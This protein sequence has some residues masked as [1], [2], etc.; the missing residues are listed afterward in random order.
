MLL[1][2]APPRLQAQAG[3][4]TEGALFLLLPIGARAVGMGLAAVAARGTSESAWWNPAGLSG[5]PARE[6]AIHHSQSLNGTGD[7]LNLVMPWRD[8]GV[9]AVAASVLDLGE[10]EPRIDSSGALGT[11]FPRQVVLAA[12]FA[13]TIGRHTRAG[14][15]YKVVQFRLDC[16][17][18]CVSL[19]ASTS[20]LDLGAQYDFGGRAPITLGAALRN[21]GVQL[22]VNDAEQSDELPTRVEAGLE[23]RPR[24]PARY[25]AQFDLRFAFA[26]VDDFTARR[27]LARLGSEVGIQ[28]T[29]FLRAGYVAR[30]Q[31]SEG[32]GPT[33]GLGF[34]IRRFVIDIGRITAG[35]SADAGQAPTHLSVRFLF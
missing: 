31:S 8:F 18:A 30:E 19:H 26:V 29:A 14:V 10:Q 24:L 28:R 2:L 22:Q 3:T 23:Y 20:A 35:L 16:T 34:V 12:S 9:I 21:V 27:P 15:T 11:L 32:G 17:G 13:T 7:A 33:I 25:A 5:Q 4:A 1:A 6:A